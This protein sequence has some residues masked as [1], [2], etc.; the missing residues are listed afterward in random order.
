MS[1]VPDLAL[2]IHWPFCLSRC[3]YCDFNAHVTRKLVDEN[4]WQRAYAAEIRHV[5]ERSGPRRITNVFFGGGTPSLMDP[6]TV[7]QVL[8]Q[9]ASTFTLEAG[10]EITLEA[11]PTS[12]EAGRFAALRD[13]G[14]NRV[15][16]GVQSLD[17]RALKFLG[18]G[19]STVEARDAV[20]TAASI[21][22]RFSFDLIYGRPAQTVPAWRAELGQALSFV[23]E[24]LSCY[25]LTIEEG[26]PFHAMQAEGKL[27]LPANETIRAMFDVTNEMLEAHGLLR[28][29]I[30]NHARPGA[31]ARHNLH[32]W[33][34]GDYAGIGP[35]A[36]GRLL[37]DG[38][39]FALRQVRDPGAWMRAVK[40][41][42]HGTEASEA[43]TP[44][45]AAREMLLMGMRLREGVDT[46]RIGIRTGITF[47]QAFRADA[48]ARACQEGLAERTG[49]RVRATV[50]GFPVLDALLGEIS[51]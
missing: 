51:S 47:P 26:T 16:I 32:C 49:A 10:A 37:V 50:V 39:I 20:E 7:G 46:N 25:Q 15:S 14:V 12:V 2:Y 28:Y 29:E 48:L 13:A 3:P 22:S 44:E 27:S 36:H 24:H 42:G 31:E 6:A 11:N 45:A 1:Q 41:N 19:H 38:K 34:Y 30:S 40:E 33:R 18:R 5:R 35:G 21:F 9:A 4:S 43:L 8:E 17:D 23:G